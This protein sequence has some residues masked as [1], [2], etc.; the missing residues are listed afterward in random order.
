MLFLHGRKI[1]RDHER[2]MLGQL[3]EMAGPAPV[4]KFPVAPGRLH[5]AQRHMRPPG[6][7][8]AEVRRA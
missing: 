1:L 3:R 2:Y 5:A 8:D 7:A 4:M 6:G